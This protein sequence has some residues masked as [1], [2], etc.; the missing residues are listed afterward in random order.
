[1]SQPSDIE[2]V[3]NLLDGGDTR[4]FEIL[5]TRY[6]PRVYSLALSLV[7]D[8]YMAQ[9]VT[10]LTF[11]KAYHH[12]DAWRGNNF[13]SWLFVIANHTALDM[14]EAEKRYPRAPLDAAEVPSEDSYDEEQERLLQC[15]ERALQRLS[16]RDR[17]V[18]ELHYFQQVPLKDVARR[19]G[20]SEINIK[21]RLH[22]IRKLLKQMIND[23]YAE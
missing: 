9:E 5:L 22:R 12:I 19:L 1:M 13:L 3:R 8:D 7:H 20:L 10:Q 11:I 16:D 23:E 14:L 15:L 2:L 4:S 17:S 21:V 18:V 6:S